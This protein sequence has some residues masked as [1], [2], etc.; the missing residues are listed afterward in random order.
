MLPMSSTRILL[1]GARIIVALAALG[2]VACG[3]PRSDLSTADPASL[4]GSRP[5]GADM[6]MQPH[7]WNAPPLGG[8][9][10]SST[11]EAD[12]YLAF[13]PREPSGLG[14]PQA[15]YVQTLGTDAERASRAIVFVYITEQYGLVRLTMQIDGM[16][17]EQRHN[18]SVTAVAR[19]N[20]P[21]TRGQAEITSIK[22][23]TEALLGYPPDEARVIISWREG[24]ILL[25]VSGPNLARDEALQIAENL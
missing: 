4:S 5:G 13:K 21:N 20:D 7:D 22:G 23:G 16:S 24:P 15:I 14:A 8:V 12:G 19:N 2:M 6:G 10:V 1:V 3:A 18:S 25:I 11:D 9:K 17:A